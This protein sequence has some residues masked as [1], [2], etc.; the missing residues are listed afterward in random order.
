MPEKTT[1]LEKTLR[2]HPENV[3]PECLA[4]CTPWLSAPVHDYIAA[5]EQR[6]EIEM[7]YESALMARG[8]AAYLCPTAKS[9]APPLP[10]SL[11]EQDAAAWW[12]PGTKAAGG[13]NTAIFK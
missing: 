4:M 11:A 7:L 5:I 2:N 13:F 6:R 10:A 3:S 12:K 8:A 1:Y 9:T